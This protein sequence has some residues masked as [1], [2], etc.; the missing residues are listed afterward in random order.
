MKLKT[1]ILI[2]C[3][4]F[5][6][7]AAATYFAPGHGHG[8]REGI[9]SAAAWQRMANPGTLSEAHAFLDHNCNACHTPVKGAEATNCIV[10]H[11][12]DHDILQRQPTAFH[13]D[14]GNCRDCHSE[15]RGRHAEITKM[16]HDVLADIGRKQL[17]QAAS[18]DSE[19]AAL[20]E[21]LK[22]AADSPDA[23]SSNFVHPALTANERTLNCAT[24]HQNDDRHFGLFGQ[25]CS[26][27]HETARWSLP[28][29]RHPP[30]SSK[31]CAQ[32]HQPPPSHYMMHFNMISKKVA[33]IEHA[34][35]SQCFLCHQTTS[36]PDI[37]GVGWYKHH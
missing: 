5:A 11:A 7:L 35:V 27:C 10:C 30:A 29:F 3:L 25:D 23:T 32:C 8:G 19:S 36:W 17:E 2:A 34:D 31:D 20:L 22:K 24:C 26:S 16:E 6:A 33:G 14:V 12:N 21:W 13:A 1:A 28:E 9:T 4:V 18:P 37:R 15:H